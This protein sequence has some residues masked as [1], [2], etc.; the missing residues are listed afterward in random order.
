MQLKVEFQFALCLLFHPFSGSE[1]LATRRAD[2]PSLDQLRP[3]N[4]HAS[5]Q[6]QTVSVKDDVFMF[7]RVIGG[8]VANKTVYSPTFCLGEGGYASKGCVRRSVWRVPRPK[9]VGLHMLHGR[10]V[11][12]FIEGEEYLLGR[13]I[14][15]DVRSVDHDLRIL[16][17]LVGVRDTGEFLY[18]PAPRLC[19]ESLAVAPLADLEG[20]DT[21]TRTKPPRGAIMLRTSL[22]T[23]S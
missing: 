23:A 8:I 21:W 2:C 11:A 7:E 3:K 6:W 9:P 16:G 22:R 1:R 5:L 13:F 19:V 20:V 18:D 12:T 14:W 10:Q 15:R 17:L 4:V